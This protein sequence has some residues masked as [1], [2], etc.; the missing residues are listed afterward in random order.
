LRFN[1]NA[2]SL[3]FIASG[4]KGKRIASFFKKPSVIE[5]KF[6]E[7]LIPTERA[8]L[9]PEITSSLVNLGT[10]TCP[11]VD[12]V[13][14]ALAA[15]FNTSQE[16]RDNDTIGTNRIDNF[17][18]EYFYKFKIKKKRIHIHARIIDA[19]KKNLIFLL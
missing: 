5:V 14:I 17:I 8:S 10:A 2:F 15:W 4:G 16:T 3:T 1:S 9:N 6:T 12:G 7:F 18:V 13:V 11:E 19:F